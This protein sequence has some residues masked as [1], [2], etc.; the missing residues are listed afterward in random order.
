MVWKYAKNDK[1]NFWSLIFF[2]FKMTEYE[3]FDL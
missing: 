2:M 1:K 3:N